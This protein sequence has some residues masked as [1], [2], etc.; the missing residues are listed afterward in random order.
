MG[1]V[2]YDYDSLSAA[3]IASI[4]SA[5]VAAASGGGGGGG[6]TTIADVT[7]RVLY[8]PIDGS[9]AP[10]PAVPAAHASTK[11]RMSRRRLLQSTATDGTA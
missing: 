2:P 8:A 1:K 3:R 10:A 6:G 5:F 7:A 11:R 4:E 9:T